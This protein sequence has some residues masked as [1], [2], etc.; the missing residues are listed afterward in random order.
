MLLPNARASIIE[1]FRYACL[2]AGTFSP[3]YLLYSALTTLLILAIGVVLFN[4]VERMFMGFVTESFTAMIPW[5]TR[6]FGVSLKN[7]SRPLSVRQRIC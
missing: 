2:D 3:V 4:H 7:I 6:V 1:T 5:M